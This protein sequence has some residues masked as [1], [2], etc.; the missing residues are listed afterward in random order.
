LSNGD[1]LLCG[2]RSFDAAEP[3]KYRHKLEMWILDKSLRKPA[4][5]LGEFCD[6]GPAVSRR[7]LK[8]AWTSPG[9]R[10]IYL[11]QL[12]YEGDKPVLTGKRLLIAYKEPN[13]RLE[14]QD[15]RGPEEL[16]LIFTHYSGTPDEP[17]RF[18]EVMGLDLASGK[19]TN[20]SNSPDSYDEA[21][22]IFPDGRFTLVESDR[23]VTERNWRVDLY[24]LALDGS[25]KVERLLHFT[26]WPG[27]ISDN[28][29]ISP[30]GRWLAF[31]MGIPRIGP[32][33]GAGLLLFDLQA[34]EAAKRR[35]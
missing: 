5:S 3:M 15:F 2:N 20:Y 14:T 11:G 22:G 27:Y 10:D 30:D 16:E 34:Y 24:R 8:I 26:D 13:L 31:Q 17:F 4:V 21:E 1:F 12:S 23:H 18:S 19:I 6:E 32:G 25:G 29:V 28:G 9:Q 7:D 35:D 33:E